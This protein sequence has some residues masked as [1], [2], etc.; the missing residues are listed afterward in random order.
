MSDINHLFDEQTQ[1]F[2][3]SKKHFR[4]AMFEGMSLPRMAVACDE[5]RKNLIRPTQGTRILRPIIMQILLKFLNKHKNDPRCNEMF[6]PNYAWDIAER[7]SDCFTVF[8]LYQMQETFPEIEHQFRFEGINENWDLFSDKFN[9]S[10]L[11]DN[12]FNENYDKNHSATAYMR[13][14]NEPFREVEAEIYNLL[15][16]LMQT[17]LLDF[18]KRYSVVGNDVSEIHA[19]WEKERERKRREASPGGSFSEEDEKNTNMTSMSV[20][21]VFQPEK[22]HFNTTQRTL[23]NEVGVCYLNSIV[24]ILYYIE[25]LRNY[26][27]DSFEVDNILEEFNDLFEHIEDRKTYR[28]DAVP[29][30]TRTIEQC[31]LD[32]SGEGGNPSETFTCIVNALKSTVASIQSKRPSAGNLPIIHNILFE[33]LTFKKNEKIFPTTLS[34]SDSIF[35]QLR[36]EPEHYLLDYGRRHAIEPRLKGNVE[37]VLYAIEIRSFEKTAEIESLLRAL[38]KEYKKEGPDERAIDLYLG[39]AYVRTTNWHSYVAI[40]GKWHPYLLSY[41]CR[42]FN[43]NETRELSK[44]EAK[45]LLEN[46][47]KYQF[48]ENLLYIRESEFN[49]MNWKNLWN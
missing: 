47:H 32:V 8:V 26:I 49:K 31:N 43:N 13:K 3:S 39:K 11:R 46:H 42:I 1:L 41:S 22:Y 28:C 6:N 23:H 24:Y 17:I 12:V 15:T 5:Q 4:A 18:S 29:I 2:V 7:L 25:P 34:T 19:F 20:L 10:S 45:G 38:K 21:F 44:H 40:W 48:A 35:V 9:L 37:Y 14:Q 30:L 36:T 33:T 27:F 16:M